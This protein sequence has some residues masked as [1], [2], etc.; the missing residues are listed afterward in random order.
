MFTLAISCLTTSSLPWFMDLTF[1]VPMHYC[2]YGIGLYLHGAG[3]SMRKYYISKGREAPTR[4]QTLEQQL[5]RAGGACTLPDW[6]WEDTPSPRAKEKPQQNCR[7][8]EIA[9]RSKPHI[10]QR[11]LESSD[12]PCVHQ[13]PD[14]PWRLRTVF[15][16]L[17][18]GYRS[19][20]ECFGSNG[21]GCSRPGYGISPLGVGHH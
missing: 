15:E 7:R 14:T 10:C 2:S 6:L 19:A 18:R 17:L 9:Y 12:I 11:C 16:C 8:S 1:H 4:W 3:V 13:D 21:S 5:C 20:V